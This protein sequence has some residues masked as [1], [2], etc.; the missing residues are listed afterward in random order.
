MLIL[1]AKPLLFKIK[2]PSGLAN[3]LIIFY[4]WIVSGYML[5][6][7]PLFSGFD[8]GFVCCSYYENESEEFKRK[9]IEL[10]PELW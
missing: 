8:V 7:F 6:D 3:S 10:T 1:Q 4:F 2:A 5:D 9:G